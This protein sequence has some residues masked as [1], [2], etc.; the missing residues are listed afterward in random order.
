V[1]GF[2]I[3]LSYSV[4]GE[5]LY[6]NGVLL[7]RGVDYTATN[8]TSIT[9]STA[10]VV[11]DLVT[12]ISQN[13]F[14]IAN[15]IPLNT[16]TAKGDLIVGTGASTVTNLPVGADGTTLVANSA[17][18]TGMA[19]AT[20]VG[21]LAN[22]IING[23]MDVWQRNTSFSLSAAVGY[24]ADRWYYYFTPAGTISRISTADT[25]NLPNIQYAS[26]IQRNSGNTSTGLI[27]ISQ[28]L[29][30]VNS[31]PFAGKTV[32]LS[33]YARAGANYSSTSN[34]FSVG[35]NTGTGTDQIVQN[36]YTGQSSP[37]GVLAT[38]TTTWQR[39][40]Y[41]G[42]IPTTATE[43]GIFFGYT[44]TGTAGAN[45]YYDITGVQIDLGTYTAT[46]APAFRRSGGTLQGELA[47]CQR[48]YFRNAANGTSYVVLSSFGTGVSTSSVQIPIV[49]PVTMRT[50]PTALEYGG[51]FRLVDGSSPFNLTSPT[52]SLVNVSASIGN[53]NANGATG[54]T[55]YHSYALSDQSAGSAYY[56]ISAEL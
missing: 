19:W 38:L 42:T 9:L 45:D 43:L 50:I 20:P 39:F 29:E 44:P 32:T 35:L 33:F 15:A 26:R 3:T 56:G 47:A 5:Q 37:I 11:G 25:T 34:T 12:V 55:Q 6:V 28:S 46:T 23:G 24:G 2:S 31:I 7:E 13:T 54:L 22:P 10:L 18:A 48:Y 49:Y 52:F 53:L 17:S 14:A 16:V 30:T 21:S 41:S 8:G 40:A 4:G 27:Q 51:T 36:G 1:D